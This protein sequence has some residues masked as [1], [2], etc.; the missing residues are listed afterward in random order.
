MAD[1]KRFENQSRSKLAVLDENARVFQMSRRARRRS[2]AGDAAGAGKLAK[3]AGVLIAICL[4]GAV[5]LYAGVR[6]YLHSD[7]FRLL[8]S[9]QVSR[10]A[11]VKGEFSPFIWEGLA[12]RTEAFSATSNAAIRDLRIDGLQ[13]EVGL[14]GV[15]RGVWEL[16]NSQIRRL[17]ISLDAR[18]SATGSLPKISEPQALKPTSKSG[19]LPRKVEVHG[20]ELGQLSLSVLTDHGTMLADRMHVVVENE[21]TPGTHRVVL[22]DG[23]LRLPVAQFPE[24]RLD[25]ARIRVQPEAVFLTHLKAKA[26]SAANLESSGEWNRE[27]GTFTFGG[28][29]SEMKCDELLSEDWSR[30]L[31]GDIASDF[32]IH[33]RP[34]MTEASGKLAI[35]NGVLTAM[36]VLDALAAY[37]DTRRFRTLVL[38][39][40]HTGWRWVNGALE[41]HNLV[42]ASDSLIRLEGRVVIRGRELDGNLRLGLAPGTLASIPGAETDVFA[43]GE[44]GLMW[45]PLRLTGTLDKPREDL[46]DRLIAAAG[47]RMLET[48]PET[49]EKV[50]KFSRTLLGDDPAGA[51]Q[52]GVR[53]IED[54]SKTVR[55][56]SGILDGIL[57]SGRRTEELLPSENEQEH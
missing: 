38:S 48:L 23:T 45:T 42:L 49:G 44:R 15:G 12:L 50:L 20:V 51:V 57:G 41:I 47:L 56:V 22:S 18:K 30:R 40:A 11:G 8:L 54:S 46:T 6:R 13:T 55:E 35:T 4:L 1:A 3:W 29:V 39:E 19:W 21:K 14:D 52:K 31:T 53:M 10:A 43:P 25:S 27:T 17:Q 37:S 32:T 24:L 5:V 26:F 34:G 7:A 33:G 28:T 2:G 16:Q 9:S 36:P